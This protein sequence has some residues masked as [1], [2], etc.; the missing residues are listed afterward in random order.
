LHP[1]LE[2]LGIK[3]HVF[4]LALF[5]AVVACIVVYLINR[6]YQVG[7]LYIFLK[8]LISV[9][10]GA[11]IFGRL[12]SAFVLLRSSENSFF[13]NILYGGSVFYGGVIGGLIGAFIFCAIKRIILIEIL[14]VL[15]SLLPLG[16]SIGRIGCYLNGCCYGRH[17]DGILSVHYTVDGV[18]TRVFPTWFFEAG[19]CLILAI[20]FQ[21]FCRTT[22]RGIHTAVYLLAYS[23]FRFGIEFLRGDA[24]RGVFG[25][26]STSQIISI[27]FLI[28][29][30]F[31][32]IHSRTKNID[33]SFLYQR[34]IAP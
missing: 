18:S 1:T 25:W 34:S 30:V 28:F 5:A 15:F 31:V 27:L 13:Y 20:Y 17:Y 21:V 14:D 19:F 8:C 6:K 9:L 2:L 10:I 32:L 29:G 24:I 3:I 22:K 7:Y 4:P 12:L 26:I 33:N 16:Q 11:A 23:A